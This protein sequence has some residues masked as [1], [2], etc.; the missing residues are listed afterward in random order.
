MKNIKKKRYLFI[1]LF[2][3]I[4]LL[5][6]CFSKCNDSEIISNLL[7]I[8]ELTEDWKGKQNL[9]GEKGENRQIEIPGFSSLC[10]QSGETKQLVNFFN[11]ES[12]TDI[13]FLMTLFVEDAEVWK[14]NGLCKPGRG[15]YEINLNKPLNEGK[16]EAYL[17]IECFR[18]DG[19]QLN[20][21]KIDFTLT[22]Q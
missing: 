4:L 6:L 10:F 1:L 2:L 16:Y 18:N 5:I 8:D 20:G 14:A 21:A 7:P 12:N 9:P 19:I 3:L 11:P 22:V 17:L 13:L 15:Y